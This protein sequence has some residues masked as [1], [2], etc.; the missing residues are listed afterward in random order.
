MATILGLDY[1]TLWFL[2]VGALFSGYAILDGFD[3]GAGA[4]HLFFEKDKDRRIA[5]NAVGPVW[6]GNEVWLVIGGGA[7]FAGFPVLYATLFSSMYIPFI[8]FLMFI[9]FRAISIEF[10]GK[11]EMAWWKKLW[12]IGY[13]VSSIMLAFL[14]GVVLGNVLQG[15]QVGE[16]FQYEGSG[17]LEF[18]N[19]YALL[20]GLT[21]LALFMAHG[22][23]F[24]LLKTEGK[25]Y[26]KLTYFLNIGIIFFIISYALTTLY[27]LLFIPHLSDA[28]LNN[29]LLFIVPVLTFL[30]VA[31]LPRLASQKKYKMTF[32]FSSITISLLLIVVAIELYP[33]LLI[34]TVDPKYN[35]DIYK[36]A[37]SEKALGIMLTIVAIGT[38]L[39]IGYTLFV[40]KTFWGKVKLD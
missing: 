31:N 13:S 6:D 21:S 32:L 20:T 29:P 40:Y 35:I 14:L 16:N 27:T 33:T 19:P 10:R 12:D 7:L 11:E 1:P 18:L 39:I 26:S 8:L 5:L 3:F 28:F 37:S 24:L 23:S 17:F 22:A 30:S 2:V 38:P 25:M 9:I 34:S 4:W 36:A 15:I